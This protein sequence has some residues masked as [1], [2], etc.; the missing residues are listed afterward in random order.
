MADKTIPISKFFNQRSRPV[1]ETSRK[2][3]R[4]IH[5][6][7]L[8]EQ[9]GECVFIIGL[10]LRYIAAN[11][12][13]LTLLGYEEHEL[14][15]MPVSAVMSQDEHLGL[16]LRQDDVEVY[17]RIL[18]RK[19]GTTLPVEVS[20]SI[21]YNDRDQPAYIQS[22]ARDISERKQAEQI[23]KQQTRILSAISGATARLL[24][25]SNIDKRIPEVLESLG[26]A[27][28][29]ASC[30]LFEVTIFS[31]SPDINIQYQ[32]TKPDASAL[33]VSAAV[34]PYLTA[35]LN[36]A[37][38]FSHLPKNVEHAR[39]TDLSFTVMPI[40]G[41]LGSRS[42]LGLFDE[43]GKLSWLPSM[44]DV[45]QTAAN[46]L[47]SALQRNRYE[48]TIRLNEAR[49]RIILE[50]I[51][52]L[53]I[54][55]DLEGT[56]LDYSASPNHPLYLHR[57][58]MAGR[59]LSAIWPEDIVEKIVGPKDAEGFNKARWLEGFR[60]PYSNAIY[61]SRLHP[62]S[63]HEALILIR[64][65]TEQERLNELKSDFIN[66]AS[67]ELRTPLTS[68]ILMIEL[69]QSGGTP[70]E[71]R[72]YWQVLSSELNR[73]KIL[74][75]RLLMAGRLESGMM[76]LERGVIDLRPTLEESIR[77]VKPIASKKKINLQFE[78]PETPAHISGDNTALQQVF[79]N[80]LNN[81]TKFSPE[82]STVRVTV[83]CGETETTTTISDQGMGIPPESLPHL[84][85][86]FYRARN[87]TIAEIPGSGI[88]LYIVKSIVEE[89][90]GSI[91]VESA[92]NQGTQFIVRLKN[93]RKLE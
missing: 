86:R 82:G 52:D 87:V 38:G 55:I 4:D 47:G 19:D 36:S 2:W 34:H 51:P 79:I 89:L 35:I 84:F 1:D 64:D 20:T 10:D 78:S 25:T 12:Q 76:K 60:L 23:L 57:D 30:A 42:Y 73:Q 61:E 37:E 50:T 53:L 77:A 54:R 5:Y 41:T 48:E 15:G 69:I 81:A 68:A 7:D 39:H 22:I 71:L 45:I 63:V 43:Q 3:G 46:L 58:V 90:G 88:G 80:L 49:N 59:N 66:R 92:L 93:G 9:T 72:E 62:I 75:D 74:I 21:I 85:E 18:K 27:T 14:V 70:E 16:T 83:N 91:Q 6:R 13:A 11:P 32:W 65:V 29:V 24:Q 33:D 26:E 17:E 40:Q 31:A 28:G 56:I 8:F 44:H 67:H